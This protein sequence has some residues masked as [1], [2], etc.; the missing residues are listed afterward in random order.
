[1]RAVLAYMPTDELS[2]CSFD[3]FFERGGN[4]SFTYC[5]SAGFQSRPRQPIYVLVDVDKQSIEKPGEHGKPTSSFGNWVDHNL[6]ADQS[7]FVIEHKQEALLIG[8]YLDKQE[9]DAANLLSGNRQVLESVLAVNQDR[10][11]ALIRKQIGTSLPRM[12]TDRVFE[13]FF[14]SLSTEALIT[15][16]KKPFDASLLLDN[17]LTVY[18]QTGFVTPAKDERQELAD[19]L[20]KTPHQNLESLLLI[21]GGGRWA[22]PVTKWRIQSGVEE[23]DE[24]AFKNFWALAVPAKLVDP[25]HLLTDG[26]EAVF[27][28]LIIQDQLLPLDEVPAL[29]KA[30]V[31]SDNIDALQLLAP[32]LDQLDHKQ[33]KKI[34]KRIKGVTDISPVFMQTL[35]LLDT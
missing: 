2:H 21:W 13:S 15:S 34:R 27:T 22:N 6:A 9:G 29:V 11:K 1:M 35:D 19:V 20:D 7:S 14:A 17:L 30:L 28:S 3:T 33:I 25:M 12:L 23:M 10:L 4:L 32:Y 18:K 24:D 26:K 5:W 31:K 8:Q 16:V